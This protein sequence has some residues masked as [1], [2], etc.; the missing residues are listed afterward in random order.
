[1]IGK[2]AGA[3]TKFTEVQGW[4]PD[5]VFGVLGLATGAEIGARWLDI[6]DALAL[7][8]RAICT[9]VPTGPGTS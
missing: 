6:Y 4:F 1:M 5:D 9:A 2:V 8:T 7:P 3:A